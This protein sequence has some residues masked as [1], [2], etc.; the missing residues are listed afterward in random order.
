[1][2]YK[3]GKKM[4][5]IKM[6]GRHGDLA[7]T[8]MEKLPKGLKKQEKDP[9]VMAYGEVTGHSHRV[10]PKDHVEIFIDEKG[11]KYMH[12]KKPAELYHEEHMLTCKA[13]K[14]KKP[15]K[16]WEGYYKIEVEKEFDPWAREIRRVAD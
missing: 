10:E 15:V 2:K 3:R 1:M 16:I 11:R 8:K 12:V 9:N 14:V 7:I 13:T 5:T 6:R 4:D